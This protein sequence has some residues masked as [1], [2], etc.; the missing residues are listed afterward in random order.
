Y[1]SAYGI[2]VS[3]WGDTKEIIYCESLITLGNSTAKN[4]Q[5]EN[6]ATSKPNENAH[7][8]SSSPPANTKPTAS[9]PPSSEGTPENQNKTEDN[10]D[11][12]LV[13]TFLT[14]GIV[15]TCIAIY[16]AT[17]MLKRRRSK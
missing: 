17:L 4:A 5:E 1:Y 16:I 15:T 11:N 8:Q 7:P 10:T 12:W 3:L 14:V 13:N 2:Q 6:P 9:T